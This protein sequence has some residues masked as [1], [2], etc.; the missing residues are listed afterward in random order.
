MLSENR[1]AYA[2]ANG[3]A[4]YA[5][6]TY[7]EIG[8]QPIENTPNL[9]LFTFPSEEI[10]EK[11]WL[12]R[13]WSLSNTLTTIE[14][15]N[16]RGLPKEVPLDRLAMWVQVHRLHQNMRVESNIDAIGS[17]YFPKFIDLDR[18]GLEYNDYRLFSRMLVEVDLREPVPTGFDFP[19]TDEKTGI[20]YCEWVSFKYERLVELCYFC[21]RIG[22]NWPTC[23][24]MAEERKVNREVGLSEIYNSSLK[25]GVDSPRR[26][27]PANARIQ[28]GDG[29]SQSTTERERTRSERQSLL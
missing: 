25:A 21:G 22:H 1:I 24:L 4:Q 14:K 17:H 2:K 20:E 9:F 7:G 3:A 13:P 23:G 27:S 26:V 11:V 28:R 19:F 5:W 16:G 29:F 8:V 6:G 18:S 10:W 12:A 15:W